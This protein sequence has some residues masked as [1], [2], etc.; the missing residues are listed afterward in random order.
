MLEVFNIIIHRGYSRDQKDLVPLF[1]F[2]NAM[3]FLMLN[4]VFKI[5]FF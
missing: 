4:L 5:T 3:Q 2:Q 1:I